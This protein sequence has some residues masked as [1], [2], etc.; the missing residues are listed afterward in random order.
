[1]KTMGEFRDIISDAMD[2]F[3]LE[4]AIT[5]RH[6]IDVSDH[7]DSLYEKLK[8]HI[9][10][11]TL[12]REKVMEILKYNFPNLIRPESFWSLLTDAICSLAIDHYEEQKQHSHNDTTIP[13]VSEEDRLIVYIDY[14][15]ELIS[16]IGLLGNELDETAT[17]AH[18]H[19]WRTTRQK[20][21]EAARE[22]LNKLAKQCGLPPLKAAIKELLTPKEE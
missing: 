9:S 10:Q 8:E 5:G 13:S 3:A 22:R 7:V 19:G 12:D 18:I 4:F 20:D 17:L 11:N 14:I 2:A 6:D 1:M 16:Y 21:G 15:S